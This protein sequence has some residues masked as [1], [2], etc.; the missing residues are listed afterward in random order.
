MYKYT[1]KDVITDPND[2]RVERGDLYSFGETPLECINQA[3]WKSDAGFDTLLSV[4]EMEAKPF[5]FDQGFFPC[6]IRKKT[7]LVPFNFLTQWTR[8]NL[9]HK[10]VQYLDNEGRP[11][12]GLIMGFVVEDKTIYVLLP[13]MEKLD[14]QQFLERCKFMDGGPCG[15]YKFIKEEEQNA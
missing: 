6:I 8:D 11:T 7:R 12:E 3:N 2:E 15:E 10:V 1:Y 5:E 4:E 9:R 14:S 13:G